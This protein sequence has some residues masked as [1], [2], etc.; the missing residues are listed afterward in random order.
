LLPVIATLSALMITTKSPVS[1]CGVNIGLCLP[2]SSTAAWV[3]SR[4]RTTSVASMTC[5]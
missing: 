2:R 5:H 1:M 3:A 4:P